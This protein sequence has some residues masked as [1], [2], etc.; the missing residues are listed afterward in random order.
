MGQQM[1]TVRSRVSRGV[2]SELLADLEPIGFN[3]LHS[4]LERC[5][6]DASGVVDAIMN[7]LMQ[8]LKEARMCFGM[9]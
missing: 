8:E 4:V 5:H 1:L 3:G 7:R 2:K 6:I 9:E